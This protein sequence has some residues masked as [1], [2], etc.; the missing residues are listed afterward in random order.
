M[1]IVPWSIIQFVNKFLLCLHVIRTRTL[2]IISTEPIINE[3]D[4][5]DRKDYNN[6]NRLSSI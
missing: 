4:N 5:V 3:S 1:S 6:I 2:Y